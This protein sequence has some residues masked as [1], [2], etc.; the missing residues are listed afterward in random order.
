M[1]Q[2]TTRLELARR[3]AAQSDEASHRAAIHAAYYAVFHLC[4]DHLG[5]DTSRKGNARHT[6]VRDEIVLQPPS[7][8]WLRLAKRDY[9]TL[10]RLRALADYDNKRMIAQAEAS[11]AFALAEAI[12]EAV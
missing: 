2:Q 5:W 1:F 3:L 9:V 7:E 6:D 10:L 11:H 4:A 8:P 12:F